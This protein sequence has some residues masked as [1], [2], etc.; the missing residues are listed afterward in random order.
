MRPIREEFTSKWITFVK[1]HFF[2]KFADA[3][4]KKTIG[5]SI[6]ERGKLIRKKEELYAKY[7]SRLANTQNDKHDLE[8]KEIE[9]LLEGIEDYLEK[10]LDYDEE[11]NYEDEI[12]TK[13]EN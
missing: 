12:D 4:P 2:E 9:R 10:A 11:W 1:Q 3:K 8:E 7:E 13:D 5:I 6:E